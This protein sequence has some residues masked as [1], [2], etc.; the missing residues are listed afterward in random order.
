MTLNSPGQNNFNLP[1]FGL[2]MANPFDVAW[3]TLKAIPSPTGGGGK[4]PPPAHFRESLPPPAGFPLA[5]HEEYGKDLSHHDNAATA[6]AIQAAMDMANHPAMRARS[7]SGRDLGGP[8]DEIV[9]ALSQ[10]YSPIQQEP[11]ITRMGH[12]TDRPQMDL[13]L[14]P[15][16]GSAQAVLDALYASGQMSDD[17]HYQHMLSQEKPP[18]GSG[19]FPEVNVPLPATESDLDRLLDVNEPRVYGLPP[20]PHWLASGAPPK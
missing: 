5:H 6:A 20:T 12:H 15:P 9:E 19:G 4:S 14:K 18:R 16:A 1:P 10:R 3:A 2:Y 8:R 7:S 11:W 17:P 13:A